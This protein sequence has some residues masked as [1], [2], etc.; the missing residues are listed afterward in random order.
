MRELEYLVLDENIDIVGIL[1][2]GGMWKISGI[3]C[4]LGMLYWK[5]REGRIEG[6]LCQEE[7]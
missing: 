2:L 3:R 4:F 5:N 6:H 7:Y 1:E